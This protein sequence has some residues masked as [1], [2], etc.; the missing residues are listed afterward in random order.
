MAIRVRSPSALSCWG[1][2]ATTIVGQLVV[3]DLVPDGQRLGGSDD[4]RRM[5]RNSGS[6]VKVPVAGGVVAVA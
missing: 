3:G 5:I 1:W 4:I 2:S 6:F